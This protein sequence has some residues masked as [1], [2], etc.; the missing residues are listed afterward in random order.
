[1]EGCGQAHH[2]LLHFHEP[3]EEVDQGTVNQNTEVKQDS[4]TDQ[5]T[6][7]NTSTHS[8]SAVVDSSEVLLQVIPVK[9][10]SN[11][12]SQITRSN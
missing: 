8:V 3:K 7:C 11:S 10:I 2:T 5:S 12:D 9:V 4:M 1:M 6:S